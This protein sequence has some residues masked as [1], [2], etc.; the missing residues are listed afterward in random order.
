MGN[1][2]WVL[3]H[4][5]GIPNVRDGDSWRKGR[6]FSTGSTP[7]NPLKWGVLGRTEGVGAL[8]FEGELRSS[9]DAVGWAAPQRGLKNL[10]PL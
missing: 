2:F 4:G 7:E 6:F 8:F 3:S 5:F 10:G 9:G 1:A